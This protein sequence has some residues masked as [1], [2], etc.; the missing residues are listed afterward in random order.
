M[1][2]YVR[3]HACARTYYI[4]SSIWVI[5]HR[6][7][8]DTHPRSH[9]SPNK[10]SCPRCRAPILDTRVRSI[11]ETRNTNYC[12]CS[13]LSTSTWWQGPLAEDTAHFGPRMWRN[14]VVL[15]R[16]F[17]HCW[18]A[19]TGPEDTK[20]APGGKVNNSLSWWSTGATAAS[21]GTIVAWTLQESA[22]WSLSA[23]HKPR[24]I[25]GKRILTEKMPPY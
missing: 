18:L 1:C 10:M 21:M 19:F 12:H 11:L 9:R 22:G 6:S 3:A 17:P 5:L 15:S 13:P 8:S 14:W 4:K 25:W 7:W 20:Q 16:K 24:N 23:W 2:V